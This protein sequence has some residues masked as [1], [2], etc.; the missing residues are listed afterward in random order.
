MARNHII[1]LQKLVDGK[2]VFDWT[3]HAKVNKA[4]GKEYLQGGAIQSQL[5][6]VFDVRYCAAVGEIRLNTQQY[7]IL[8]NGAVYKIVDYD[9]FMERHRTVRLLGVSYRG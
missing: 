6:L 2:W 1:E 7:R 5:Q 3:L 9:D 8:Y 4:S